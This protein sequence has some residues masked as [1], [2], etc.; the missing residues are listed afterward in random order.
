M[1]LEKYKHKISLYKYILYE[2]S[3]INYV[4]YAEVEHFI[5]MILFI[6]YYKL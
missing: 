4:K 1:N 5:C 3:V 2:F 6:F